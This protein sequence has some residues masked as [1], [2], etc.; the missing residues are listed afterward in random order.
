[1]PRSGAREMCSESLKAC[2]GG[3]R[4]DGITPRGSSCLRGGVR[5]VTAGEIRSAAL[6]S[7]LLRARTE[8]RSTRSSHHQLRSE[9]HT[10]ELQSRGHL[11][12]RL[13][14]EKKKQKKTS[15]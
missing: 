7:R 12:C 6:F 1:M 15:T 9:E 3:R 8:A 14:L 2:P 11:V 10:T 13:L 4:A 5:T